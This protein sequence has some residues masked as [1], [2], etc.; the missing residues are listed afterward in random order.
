MYF[1]QTFLNQTLSLIHYLQS[2]R[3]EWIWQLTITRLLNQIYTNHVNLESLST[4]TWEDYVSWFHHMIRLY[5]SNYILPLNFDSL[6][7]FFSVFLM[8]YIS[9]FSWKRVQTS[10]PKLIRSSITESPCLLS[11]QLKFWKIYLWFYSLC[12]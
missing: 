8:S 3:I 7:F 5:A 12:F 1:T 9:I 10:I 6:F 2:L 11:P 4:L